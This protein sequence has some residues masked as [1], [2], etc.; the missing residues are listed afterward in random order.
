MH[1]TQTTRWK[2]LWE[3]TTSRES[4]MWGFCRQH[5]AALV[6]PTIRSIK[7][8]QSP[9]YGVF[10]PLLSRPFTDRNESL[11][12]SFLSPSEPFRKIWY[13]PV[14]N[15]F[16]YCGHRQTD[17]HTHRQ[18]HKPT[19]VK[20]YSLAFCE[21]KKLRKNQKQKLVSSEETVRA[22]IREGNTEA[23]LNVKLT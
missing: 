12:W 10:W 11:T 1:G 3:S 23:W 4:K 16:S 22:K 13:K 5:L 15:L 6:T 17:R 7:C 9:F 19:P 8:K 21:E 18:T 2:V 20:T 14:H